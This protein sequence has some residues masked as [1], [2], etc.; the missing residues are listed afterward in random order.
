MRKISFIFI[1]LFSINQLTAQELDCT[2]TINADKIPGSNKKIISTLNKAIT[3]FINNRRWTDYNYKFSERIKCNMTLTLVE[4]KN[5]H[6]TGNIQ[7]QASRPVYNSSYET[8]TLNF[9]DKNFKFKYVEFEPLVYSESSFKSNLVSVLSFYVYTILGMDADTFQ[10]NG[11]DDFFNKALNVAVQSQ[12][13]GYKGWNQIDGNNTRFTLIDNI[14]LP[15][16]ADFRKAVY[17][18]HLK[19]MDVM[20]KEEENAKESIYQAIKELQKLSVSRPNAF[21]LRV[22]MDSKSDE[23]VDIFSGGITFS[24][25]RNLKNILQKISPVNSNKW[26]DLE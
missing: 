24:Q 7:I 20:A 16:Y 14:L 6:F 12:Q 22:F 8:P 3:E 26:N 1:I 5:D 18:Y 11:G 15:A 21:L 13:S 9:K 10:L 2:V 25:I 17:L 19:G 23:I 4:Y